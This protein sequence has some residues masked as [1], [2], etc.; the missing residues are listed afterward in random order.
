MY[1]VILI[2]SD[3]TRRRILGET[4]RFP[5]IWKDWKWREQLL[6]HEKK[7]SRYTMRYADTEYTLCLPMYCR[8]WVIIS[9][10]CV[11]CWIFV[12]LGKYL[13]M[14]FFLEILAFSSHLTLHSTCRKIW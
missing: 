5:S 2:Y 9:L 8:V 11:W 12:L 13:V 14:K 7:T 4:R 3:I 1:Y 10:E 6:T